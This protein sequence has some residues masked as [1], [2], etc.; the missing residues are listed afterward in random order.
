MARISF[1][2]QS[3][4]IT[5]QKKAQQT[6][7][8]LLNAPPDVS[9]LVDT[10]GTIL[11][12][13]H[14]A[15]VR[16]GLPVHDL[17][18]RDAFTLISPDLA[19][20]RRTNVREAIATREP[21]VFLDDRTG[22]AYE[23]RLYPVTGPD[24]EVT[25]VAIHSH[26]VTTERKA[27][28]ALKESEEK[29][30]LVVE[31]SQD[32][33]YVYRDNRF[34][35]VNRQVEE[36]S[37]FSHDE[38]MEHELWDFIHPDDRKPLKAAAAKRFA[39]GHVSSEF[40]TRILCKNGEV[41]AAE[42]FVDLVDLQGK[43]AIL[44][45]ARDITEKKRAE[46]TLREREEQL[47]SLSDNLPSGI[48]YQGIIDPDG[49]RRFVYISAGVE[50]VHE[51]TADEV[52]RDPSLLYNQVVEV[53]R[54][55]LRDAEDRASRTMSPLNF[56]VRI[57][58]PSGI[59][60]WVLLRSAPR[61]LPGG[62]ICWDGIELDITATKLADEQL[63]AAYEELAAS[64]EELKGQFDSLK[65]GQELLWES[66]ELHR[67]LLM[68]SP[69]GIAMVD[70]QGIL[71]YVSPK[72]LEMFGLS[73]PEE[74][75][76]TRVL[77]WMT[78]DD[79]G[80]VGQRLAKVLSDETFTS[81]IYKAHRRDG[82]TFI[83][84]MHS[85]ALHNSNGSV[86]GL[87]SILRDITDWRRA[88]EELRTSEENYRHI[89]E[90]MQDV[91]YRVD[92]EGIITMISP[93]GAHLVGFDSADEIIGK[94]RATDFYADPKQ[95]DEFLS[96]LRQEH[97]V[98]G[99][100][101][102]LKDR[103]GNLHY[104]TASSRLL[105]DRDGTVNGIEGILHEVTHLKRVEDALRQANRQIT[106][107]TSITRHDIR[108]QLTALGTWLELSRASVSDPDRMLKLITKEQ[109]IASIIEEQINFTTLFEEMG[110]KDAAWQDPAPL[111]R[112][113]ES[114]LPFKEVRLVVDL[115]GI[116][117]F[118]DPLFEMVFYNLLDNALRYGGD[119]LTTI[120]VSVRDADPD[121]V[122]VI[123]DN[124][125][126]ISETDKARLFDHGYGKNTGLGLF[127]AREILSIT[128]LTLRETGIPGK[129][130]RFEILVPSGKYRSI[131]T[132][133]PGI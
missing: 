26:D 16:F 133:S 66:E 127:L 39:G 34:L 10:R 128:G 104:A 93:Y 70:T 122:L 109:H 59:K 89:I 119:P 28:E 105:Y 114:S 43:P 84:E 45:I 29:Y 57:R 23:N 44:G 51:V 110:V 55:L 48:V 40:Q 53:D 20:L 117:I 88:E 24:G 97:V 71:T 61:T 107:M 111:V 38:L 5:E 3:V 118:A 56:E 41:R 125:K 65:A 22:Q 123:E 19:E 14:A 35:F 99:Y 37:G 17:I 27:K 64:K 106:L 85:A 120:R 121:L 126:G 92:R 6:I 31:H 131:D 116:E 103:Y 46:A 7:T 98:S 8:A 79:R 74:A 94:Y 47:R 62:G 36:I 77:E 58:T 115:P 2:T 13:N 33:I 49:T 68:A 100:S 67:N 113:A 75:I 87:I 96:Y 32:S 50:R 42:F 102:T 124:G 4:D 54:L 91:F 63:R 69:D 30:R 90:N 73:R 21:L 112:K 60:R 72:A 86:R 1:N 76:G 83:V 9:L 11:A 25:A 18:G 12:A 129:G 78:G 95:R 52:L 108:N 15:T 130:A 132:V 101:L 81:N 80:L 82:S